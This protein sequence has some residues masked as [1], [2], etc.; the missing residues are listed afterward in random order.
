LREKICNAFT[1]VNEVN[2][3]DGRG[4]NTYVANKKRKRALCNTAAT[5][6]KDAAGDER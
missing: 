1:V 4:V 3:G 6:Y 2:N 5:K